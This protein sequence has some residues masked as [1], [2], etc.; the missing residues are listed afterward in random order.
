MTTGKGTRLIPW[1]RNTLLGI[2]IVA[3]AGTVYLYFAWMGT[4]WEKSDQKERMLEHLSQKY[5]TE[6]NVRKVIYSALAE[7]YQGYAYPTGHP[8]AEF[9]IRQDAQGTGGYSDVYVKAIW[10]TELS[11]ELRDRIM[12]L[13]PEVV[14]SSFVVEDLSTE[15]MARHRPTY[16]E[17][18]ASPMMCAIKMTIP[19]DWSTLTDEQKGTERNRIEQLSRLLQD[20]RFPVLTE[21]AYSDN[22]QT[23]YEKANVIFI[24][25]DGSMKESSLP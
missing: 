20:M 6:F 1:L 17:I 19:E 21:I 13:F 14:L 16:Q 11:V 4:P 10:N 22:E 5:G 15:L 24:L 8:E 9:I 2:G 3:L 7:S 23:F 12:A 25:E 18:G